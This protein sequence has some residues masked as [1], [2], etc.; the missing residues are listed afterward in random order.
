M[1]LRPRAGLD[2]CLCA[3]D[4]E[5][6]VSPIENRR[7]R[8]QRL[9][10]SILKFLCDGPYRLRVKITTKPN[11]RPSRSA[12]LPDLEL[13]IPP[14]FQHHHPR[15]VIR[16]LYGPADTAFATSLDERMDPVREFRLPG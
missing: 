6:R 2:T 10:R 3:R 11:Y 4:S 16:F 9:P 13:D 8:Q 7:Y 14:P 5:G 15:R 1:S 12:G